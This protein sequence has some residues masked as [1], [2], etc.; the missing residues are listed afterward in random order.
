MGVQA[1]G[2]EGDIIGEEESRILPTEGDDKIS[3]ERKTPCVFS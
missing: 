3:L 1:V 2:E